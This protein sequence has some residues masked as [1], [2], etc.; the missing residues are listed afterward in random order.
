MKKKYLNHPCPVCKGRVYALRITR[1]YCGDDC[2]AKH[3]RNARNQIQDRVEYEYLMD[4]EYLQ[5]FSRN[6][7]VFESVLGPNYNSMSVNI[8]EF[9]SHKFQLTECS[10]KTMVDNKEVYYLSNYKYWTEGEILHVERTSPSPKYND[11]VVGRWL[12]CYPELGDRA[13][14]SKG[15][16]EVLKNRVLEL[17]MVW[18][19]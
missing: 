9:R 13:G 19:E 10:Y 16:L 4:R 6:L 2:K 12:L 8:G 17:G 1:I 14:F 3:H 15:E 18:R 7:Y 5:L 11:S